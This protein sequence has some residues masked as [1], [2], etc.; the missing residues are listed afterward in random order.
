MDADGATNFAKLFLEPDKHKEAIFVKYY[1]EEKRTHDWSV[2][3]LPLPYGRP[4]MDNPT[5]DLIDLY[6][7]LDRNICKSSSKQGR[8][9]SRRIY[10]P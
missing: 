5:L 7:N 2:F 1:L 8:M 3:R 4:A 10:D 9:V 6:D